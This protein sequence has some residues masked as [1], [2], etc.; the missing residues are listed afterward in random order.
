M[1]GDACDFWDDRTVCPPRFMPN[2]CGLGG[3]S[4]MALTAFG[5]GVMGLTRRRW[6]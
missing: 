1:L 2:I 6:G 3:V 5:L 4:T